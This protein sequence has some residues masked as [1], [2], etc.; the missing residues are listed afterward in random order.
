MM[1]DPNAD[2][3]GSGSGTAGDEGVSRPGDPPQGGGIAQPGDPPDGSTT[4]KEPY[5]ES[6]AGDPPQGGGA[7]A[8]G[9]PPQ[10]GGA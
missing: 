5:D 9:D 8:P 7:A 3:T 6:A 1:E 2:P 4:D 10:G